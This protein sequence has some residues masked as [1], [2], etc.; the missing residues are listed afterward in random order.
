MGKAARNRQRRREERDLGREEVA[1]DHV[2]A[3]LNGLA[4][5]RDLRSLISKHPELLSDATQER[6]AAHAAEPAIGA[7]FM[8]QRELLLSAR[9]DIATAW[10]AYKVAM[11]EFRAGISEIG[12]EVDAVAALVDVRKDEEALCRIETVLPNARRLDHRP[13]VTQLLDQQGRLLLRRQAGDRRDNLEGSIGA[14]WGSLAGVLEPDQA[15]DILMHLALAFGERLV[16]DRRDNIEAAIGF[17]R[18]A[19]DLV[20][21]PDLR[22]ILQ[23]NLATLLLRREAGDRAANLREARDLCR[24]ALTW[25]RPDRDADDWAYTQL[26]LGAIIEKLADANGVIPEAVT[27]FEQV[28]AQRDRVTERW[29]VAE[30][31]RALA[32]MYLNAASVSAERILAAHERYGSVDAA[33]D[34]DA[35][36]ERA[37]DLLEAAL[38]FARDAPDQLVLGRTLA[39]LS[40]VHER[41]GRPDDQITFANEALTILRP[42]SEPSACLEVAAGLGATHTNLGRWDD[43]VAAYHLA[44]EASDLLLRRR[45]HTVGLRKEMRRTGTLHRWASVALARSGAPLEAA[46][47]LEEGRTRELR[48]RFALEVVSASVLDGLPSDLAEEYNNAVADLARAP[49]GA[50]GA[51]AADQYQAV[52]AKIRAVEGFATFGIGAPLGD[53]AAAVGPKRPLLYVNPAPGGT[54]LLLVQHAA[55]GDPVASTTFLNGVE[56][57]DIFMQLMVTGHELGDEGDNRVRSYLIDAGAGGDEPAPGE[58]QATL[59]TL[60]PWLGE[61]VARPIHELLDDVEAESASLVLCGPIASA[62]LHAAAW[63]GPTGSRCLLDGF[64]VRYVPSAALAATAQRRAE[65]RSGS[66]GRF[67]ALGDP[68]RNLPGAVAEVRELERLFGGAADVAVHDEANVGFLHDYADGASHLHLAC[69]ASGGLFDGADAVVQLANGNVSVFDLTTM[70]ALTTRLVAVSACQTGQAEIAGSPDEV[71]SIGTA[72]VAAGTA[73]ALVSLWPVDDAATAL[74]MVKVYEEMVDRCSSPPEALRRGQLWLRELT[75]AE[76]ATFLKRHP[77]LAAEFRQRA[78]RGVLPGPRSP[79]GGAAS[80]SRPYG[81]EE[82][83]AAFVAVGA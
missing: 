63:Q 35:A 68:C 71:L 69:H 20:V 44:L 17:V 9:S 78:E 23:H 26:T 58:F 29:L 54:M 75:E 37:R 60:L 64:E 21:D 24:T 50:A 48:E 33:Y 42:T 14:L 67:V 47:V 2:L 32:L 31:H 81:S 4:D 27:V 28:I 45:V 43:A 3:E 83:W 72:M 76:E 82:L 8:L 19:L 1:G 77:H 30:A 59:E 70:P 65:Q 51:P 11:D 40:D 73:C 62:P 7:T 25:R 10:M 55:G 57:M 61:H 5:L 39:A 36:L 41:L 18:E 80:A 13:L 53:L 46:A 12:D 34:N 22:A 66:P 56:A 38:P 52:V 79:T 15:A 74:L 16:D 49:L 6:L